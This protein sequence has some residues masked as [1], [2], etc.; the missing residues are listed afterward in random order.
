MA[1]YIEREAL[2]LKLH[3]A[4]SLYESPN[5][6][7]APVSFGSMLGMQG[8][9]KIVVDCPAADVAEVR[10]GEWVYDKYGNPH[11]SECGE[12]QGAGTPYCPRC[13]AYMDEEDEG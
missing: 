7:C 11:C 4:L 13:G 3:N 12:E 10:S 5:P 1:E 9:V 8:A 6:K 2:L